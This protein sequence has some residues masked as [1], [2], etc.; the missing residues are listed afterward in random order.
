[1]QTSLNLNISTKMKRIV[2]VMLF[3][4]L[5]FSGFSQEDTTK[6]KEVKPWKTEG[7]LQLNF[8]QVFINDYWVAGGANSLSA[9]GVVKLSADYLQ[10]KTSWD[11][12][13]NFAQGRMIQGDEDAR[14]T[15]D[16]LDF[17]STY[18]YNAKGKW[19]YAANYTL[20]TQL[21]DGYN[22]PDVTTPISGAFAPA[23][24]LYSLGIQYK[25]SEDFL[26]LAS[27]FTGKT[28]LVLNSD[29]SDLGAFGVEP[30]ST[31]YS[32]FGMY[33]KLKYKKEIFKNVNFSTKLDLFGD[34]QAISVWD[35]DWELAINM[36]VNN[37]L[38]ANILTQLIYNKDMS[39]E[40]QFKEVLGLG[41]GVKF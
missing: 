34:Y 10:G 1:M 40:I 13:L 20:K 32:K 41:L 11:N 27:P 19:Y 26:F 35:V 24:M 22:Y 25:P 5:F 30:G 21:F 17:S 37:W 6:A 18:G 14:K 31:S 3:S 38:S 7:M 23:E 39:S 9:L 15:D 8:S 28:I 16:K 2:F 29:L 33:F 36:K 12:D 4:M